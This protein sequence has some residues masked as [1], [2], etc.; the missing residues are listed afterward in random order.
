[1]EVLTREHELSAAG[2]GLPVFDVDSLISELAVKYPKQQEPTQATV[3]VI[4]PSEE[5][6]QAETQS[7]PVFDVDSLI[8]ELAVKYPKQQEPVDTEVTSEPGRSGGGISFFERDTSEFALSDEQIKLI[9]TDWSDNPLTE[10]ETPADRDNALTTNIGIEEQDT[11]NGKFDQFA[12]FEADLA[13]IDQRI[14][15]LESPAI[16]IGESSV[17][18]QEI[19]KIESTIQEQIVTPL[20]ALDSATQKATRPERQKV[21]SWIG[22]A[23]AVI[24]IN[25]VVLSG[26][27]VSPRTGEDNTPR[28]DAIAT[29]LALDIRAATAASPIVVESEQVPVE[30]EQFLPKPGELVG[31]LRDPVT[32]EEIQII[33]YSE[34]EDI[35]LL[36][37]VTDIGDATIDFLTPDP[38]PNIGCDAADAREQAREAETG[39][40]HIRRI[41]RYRNS[42]ITPDN[43][44]GLVAHHQ[45]VAGHQTSIK[46]TD[47]EQPVYLSVLPGQ[48][49]NAV[50]FGHG[51]TFSA[52]FA[53]MALHQEGDTLFFD[54]ED[55]NTYEYRVV[56]FDIIKADNSFDIYNYSY[57]GNEYTMT[58]SWCVDE[59]GETGDKSHRA[60]L[61]LIRVDHLK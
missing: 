59:S 34:Q 5:V 17:S 9:I 45:P 41:E 39:R 16:P 40:N 47:A 38:T 58:L 2:R 30:P 26:Y 50:L 22:R 20:P 55:G 24:A 43:P 1:M 11:S 51:S 14:V 18:D 28:G 53:D 37:E 44:S 52:A 4:P 48:K 57:P 7:L 3:S 23:A 46:T 31:V 21:R 33:E 8:S 10:S 29:E 25:A 32:C 42:A 13:E 36:N 56:G 15:E 35:D 60:A 49:G 6:R 19:T 54:S 27:V 12:F 61:R